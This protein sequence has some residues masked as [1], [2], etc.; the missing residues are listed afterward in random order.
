MELKKLLEDA[1]ER[2]SNEIGETFKLSD[3]HNTINKNELENMLD[4]LK[5]T[6][7]FKNVESLEIIKSTFLETKEGKI[8]ETNFIPLEDGLQFGGKCFIYEIVMLPKNYD[9]KTIHNPVKDGVTLTPVM[10]DDEYKPTR[11][12]VV[13]FSPEQ[14]Q[15]GSV[16][17]EDRLNDILERAKKA[18]MSKEE[19]FTPIREYGYY[20]RG[21]FEKV[22]D[23][24]KISKEELTS[25]IID[26]EKQNYFVDFYLALVLNSHDEEV[27][28]MEMRKAYIPKKHIEHFKDGR[29]KFLSEEEFNKKIKELGI[30][31][32]III[33][34]K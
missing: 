27:T 11:R 29:T 3:G 17:E 6:N 18:L 14:L 22:R 7:E 23:K 20:I 9:M 5:Q 31:D 15:D 26:F 32:E 24:T 4:F 25:P 2:H 34:E 30:E 16:T 21:V 19:E 12:L 1:F 33:L 10:Y 8:Y 28:T 13:E